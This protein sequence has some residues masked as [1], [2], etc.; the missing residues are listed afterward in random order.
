MSKVL[1]NVFNKAITSGTGNVNG[2]MFD[3]WSGNGELESKYNL[4]IEPKGEI[5]FKHWGTETLRLEYVQDNSY[6]I[7][8]IYGESKSDRDS[9]TE[10]LRMLKSKFTILN[11]DIHFHYYPSKG[12][13]ETH[14]KYNDTLIKDF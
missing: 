11:G 14:S 3:Q 12:T 4:T 13:F 7:T 6:L 2:R 8:S 10:M 5:I 1:E 9:L